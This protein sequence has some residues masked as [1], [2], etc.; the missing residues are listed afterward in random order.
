MLGAHRDE[1]SL[2]AL[3]SISNLKGSSNGVAS[4]A[5]DKNYR[6]AQV[7]DIHSAMEKLSGETD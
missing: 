5:R 6:S 4:P 1:E 3:T 7:I 2:A